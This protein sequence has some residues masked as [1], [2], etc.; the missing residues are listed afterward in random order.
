[1]NAVPHNPATVMVIG[2]ANIDIVGTSEQRLAWADSN[3]GRVLTTPGGVGRNIAENLGRLGRSTALCTVVGDDAFGAELLRSVRAAGVDTTASRVVA[4]RASSSY[5][6]VHGPE[7]ELAA[8]VNDMSI[9][10]AL[11]GASLAE[12]Q[13]LLNAASAWVLDCNLQESAMAWLFSQRPRPPVYVDAV[14]AFKVQRLRP[15]LSEIRLLKLN[16]QEACALAGLPTL[17][18]LPDWIA[19]A[20]W[21]HAEGVQ[22]VVLS[23]RARGVYWSE[24]GGHAGLQPPLPSTKINSTGAGDALLAGVVHQCEAGAHLGQ[25]V[26]FGAACAALT[27]ASPASCNPQLSVAAAQQLLQATA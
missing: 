11:D 27:L 12:R 20:A 5:L 26:A 15:W 7:G 18:A 9:L 23:L 13:A 2:A 19:A 17:D 22:R 1:M 6:S 21:L 25:A 8:A 14:S 24:R 10:D 16:G 3:P 4:G